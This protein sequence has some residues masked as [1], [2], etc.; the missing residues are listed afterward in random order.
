MRLSC[1]VAY[2]NPPIVTSGLK[3]NTCNGMSIPCGNFAVILGKGMEAACL[4]VHLSER[5]RHYKGS[6]LRCQGKPL[7]L[8]SLPIPNS[9]FQT[10]H[11]K[12]TPR[13]L[14]RKEPGKTDSCE[15]II[16]RLQQPVQRPVLRSARGTVSRKRSQGQS[17][18]RTL[19]TKDRR[20]ARRRYQHEAWD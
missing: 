19:R 4:Q 8:S 11:S 16:S 7:N 5:K 6:C 12:K 9:T 3:K 1:S 13:F 10:P 15:S 2:S 18:G 14:P 17:C 20:R